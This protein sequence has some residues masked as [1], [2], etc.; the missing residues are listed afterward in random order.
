MMFA[1]LRGVER[2]WL[3]LFPLAPGLRAQ[4]AGGGVLVQCTQV[5]TSFETGPNRCNGVIETRRCCAFSFEV[6]NVSASPM[7]RFWLE[8]EAGDGAVTCYDH[9]DPFGNGDLSI[10]GCVASM[11]YAWDGK[12][13]MALPGQNRGV[14]RVDCAPA[15]PPGGS[16]TGKLNIDA[17]TGP[18]LAGHP[19]PPG[20]IQVHGTVNPPDSLGASCAAGTFSAHESSQQAL[21]WTQASVWCCC[22]SNPVSYCT[23]GRSSSSCQALISAHGTSSATAT[24]GFFLRADDVQG[25]DAGTNG[26]FFY[27][28]HGRQAVPWGNPASGCPTYQCVRAPTRRG[29]LQNGG[30][31][32]GNCDALFLEDVNARWTAKPAHNPGAGATL[33]G[34]LWYRD[35][36][37]PCIGGMA[38]S[39]TALSDAVEWTVC[40]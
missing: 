34:Q 8:I 7:S 2:V 14:V 12:G 18:I 27:G 15:I 19:P 3:L 35:R 9:G 37:N 6:T 23:A 5:A 40:P 28:I 17:A 29:A 30:G 24:S 25:S 32:N 33:Q 39:T 11:C 26:L 36:R 13:Y 10:P 20:C 16:V 1:S 38:Q 31:S 4:V 21:F 22:E